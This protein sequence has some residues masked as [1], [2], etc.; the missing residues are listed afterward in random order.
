MSRNCDY[1]ATTMAETL[2]R[3]NDA[4]TTRRAALRHKPLYPI[5]QSIEADQPENK[6]T[7]FG[8]PQT[9]SVHAVQLGER[10]DLKGLEIGDCF[11]K[12]PLA[13]RTSRDA[14]VVVF[15]TGAVVFFAADGA[16]KDAILQQ[17]QERIIS[18]LPEADAETLLIA[19]DPAGDD[20]VGPSGNVSLKSADPHR[21]LVVAEVL[22]GAVALS[23]EERRIA[24]SFD[25]VAEIAEDL[26]AGRLTGRSQREI[27][28]DIGDSLAV[29]S[30][31]ASRTS[32]D[33]KPD[34]LWDHPELER[35][36][37]KLSDEY[38]TRAR[39]SA[40]TQK[41]AV[42]RDSADTLSNLLST[43]TSHRLEW[44]IIALIAFEIALG[45]YDRLWK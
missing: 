35:L 9:L 43:R 5:G 6:M 19:V 44:Y 36:W 18:R 2:A 40:M 1:C 34:V 22:A 24:R 30:R 38:D 26:K 23:H 21:L 20:T 7:T 32:F 11:S 27:L 13:F 15:K 3:G 12:I 8:A 10:L 45:L 17:L 42:I 39:A 25:R 29:Q 14:T 41:L 28:S 33:D 16:Q 37:M 31:L 4:A